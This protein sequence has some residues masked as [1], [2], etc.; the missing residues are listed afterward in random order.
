MLKLSGSDLSAI[1]KYT[2]QIS[3]EYEKIER[4]RLNGDGRKN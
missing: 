2:L 3:S 1:M 4:K